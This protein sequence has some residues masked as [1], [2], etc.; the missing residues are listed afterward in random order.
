MNKNET[1]SDGINKCDKTSCM[2]SVDRFMR[3]IP[4]RDNPNKKALIYIP[5]TL[6][7]RQLSTHNLSSPQ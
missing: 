2:G 4:R 1:S 3:L 7:L 5:Y 6:C